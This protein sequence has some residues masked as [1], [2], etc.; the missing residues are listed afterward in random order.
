MAIVS[1]ALC[2]CATTGRDVQNGPG[3]PE[4]DAR[5]HGRM[6]VATFGLG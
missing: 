1:A 4:I 5:A 6:E 3:L 2:G